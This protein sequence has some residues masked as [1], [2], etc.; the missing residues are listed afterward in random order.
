MD[1][2]NLSPRGSSIKT[3]LRTPDK[4]LEDFLIGIGLHQLLILSPYMF[5]L[6]LDVL[7]KH[8]QESVTKC[9]FFVDDIVLVEDSE[10]ELNW[11]L[12]M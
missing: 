3:G 8:I 4:A 11:K 10:E 6:V 9:M 12:E 1:I 7:I 5:T 2:I